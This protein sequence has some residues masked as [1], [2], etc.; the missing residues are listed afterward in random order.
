MNFIKEMAPAHFYKYLVVSPMSRLNVISR[1][2]RNCWGA[3]NNSSARN[4]CSNI[5][6]INDRCCRHRD[7]LLHDGLLH[8]SHDRR[9]HLLLLQ[10]SLELLEE[11]LLF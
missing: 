3:R 7:L 8:G 4:V 6:C 1:N 10:L 9:L 11:L 2:I 5:I